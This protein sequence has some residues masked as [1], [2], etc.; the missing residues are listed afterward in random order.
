MGFS[1]TTSVYPEY[2]VTDRTEFSLYI[3]YCIQI[4]VKRNM[5]YIFQIEILTAKLK[6]TN[7][8]T[9]DSRV[10][11]LLQYIIPTFLLEYGESLEIVE[12]STL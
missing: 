2:S 6:P 12:M 9:N 1:W 8:F 10:L 4:V 11:L 5:T 3:T 7:N